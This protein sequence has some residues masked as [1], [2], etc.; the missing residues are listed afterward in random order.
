MMSSLVH[1]PTKYGLSLRHMLHLGE[2]KRK[3]APQIPLAYTL[4]MS[5]PHEIRT[6]E[7]AVLMCK[8]QVLLTSIYFTT[9][10]TMK[11]SQILA[12]LIP[13]PLGKT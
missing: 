4:Q 1:T 7:E 10:I 3:R 6:S 8:T 2:T 12:M 9:I 5:C 11:Y 13:V